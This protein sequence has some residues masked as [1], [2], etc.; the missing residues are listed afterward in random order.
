MNR[1][2]A[3]PFHPTCFDIFT[4]LSKQ[5]LGCIDIHGLMSWRNLGFRGD[6]NRNF[7]QDENVRRATEQMWAHHRRSEYLA[8]NPLYIPALALILCAAVQDDPKFSAQNGAFAI[9]QVRQSSRR[10]NTVLQDPFLKLPQELREHIVGYLDSPD[11]APLRLASRA[12]QQLPVSLWYTLLRRETPWLW[13]VWSDHKPLLWTALEVPWIKAEEKERQEYAKDLERRRNVVKQEM[14]EILEEWNNGEQG[15]AG[16]DAKK[17]AQK[18]VETVQMLPRDRTNWYQLYRDITV[19][20]KELRGLWN[21]ERI[22]RDVEEI[23]GQ[24]KMLR[25]EGKIED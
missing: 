25:E 10:Q 6:P 11:I 9:P 3:M 4:R 2:I 23:V 18:L 13:E 1:E 19:H 12:F 16:P 5:H 24:I 7:S 14:P 8:A 22:W 17:E 21:R 15:Y 20:W